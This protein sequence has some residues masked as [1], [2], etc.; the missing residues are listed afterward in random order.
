M[1]SDLYIYFLGVLLVK[2][3]YVYDVN[4]FNVKLILGNFVVYYI[5]VSSNILLFGVGNL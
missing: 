1:F 2:E 3:N 4:I 5:G